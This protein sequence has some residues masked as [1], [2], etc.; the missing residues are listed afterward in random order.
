[1][2]STTDIESFFSSFP[3]SELQKGEMLLN[4]DE[5]VKNLYY[6]LNGYIRMYSLLPNGNELTVTIFKPGSY[7]PLFLVIDGSKNTYYY[8]AF[9]HIEVQQAPATEVVRFL[10]SNTETL[11]DAT[12]RISV[13]LRGLVENLQYQLFGSVRQRLIATI[14][15]LSKRFGQDSKTGVNIALPLTHQ[16]IAGFMGVA[17]ETVS[18]EMKKLQKERAI[19][20]D[21]KHV[22]VINTIAL[23]QE[24]GI[25]E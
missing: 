7:I 13:G 9:T 24:M 3:K 5:P 21:Y 14:L 16:D 6:L 18:V 22:T 1:M 8:E 10:K 12:R 23:Q 2:K 15:M 11:F 17:R 4:P 25:E 19:S 20:Y